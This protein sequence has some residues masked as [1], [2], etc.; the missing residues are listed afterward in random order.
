[1]KESDTEWETRFQQLVE[2][3]STHFDCNNVPLEYRRHPDLGKWLSD[4][5]ASYMNGTL[6]D[7]RK[8][9]L[10][11]IGV[12]LSDSHTKWELRFQQLLDYKKTKGDCNVPRYFST[13]PQLGQ[14]VVYQRQMSNKKNKLSNERKDKLN[15]IGFVWD[16]R[17]VDWDTRFEQLCQYE[18]AHGNCDVPQ[19]YELNKE[20]GHWVS[21]QRF[22]KGKHSLPKGREVKLESIGFVW[23]KRNTDWDIRFEQLVKYKRTHGDCE[24]PTHYEL[25]Q[26][27]GRW[28]VNHRY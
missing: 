2:Y 13:H 5:R 9:V 1:M 14:W 8:D 12:V 25:N 24:V 7:E 11:R 18:R 23:D 26:E 27:L 19:S 17:L 10:K 3:K 15:L 4:Q 22:F 6:N 21:N 16:R 20:L 28:A